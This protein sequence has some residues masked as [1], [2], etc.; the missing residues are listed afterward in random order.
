[1][2]SRVASVD[3]DTKEAPAVAR[4]GLWLRAYGW[5]TKAL[6]SVL[7]IIFVTLTLDVLWGVF[8]R[9]V[10]GH[11]SRFTEEL[12]IYLLVWLSLLGAALTYAEHGHLGVDYFVKKLHPAA[13]KVAEIAVELLVMAFSALALV[14]GGWD[15]VSQNLE[16]G[17]VSPALGIEVGYVYL[18]V[19]L[20]GVFLIV[21][22]IAHLALMAQASLSEREN[23]KEQG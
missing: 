18:A 4:G 9:H 12:A 15:L 17:Q 22:A 14:Y 2:T 1:M 3:D 6:E 13:Q 19:P 20:S 8:S 21:F 11:Q 23:Q 16:T 5:L 10:M 7:I